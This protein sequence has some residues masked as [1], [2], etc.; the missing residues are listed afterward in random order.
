MTHHGDA[1]SINVV[2]A[3]VDENGDA[4]RNLLDM[5]GLN[6]DIAFRDLDED[7]VPFLDGPW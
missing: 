4:Y 1:L 7:V 5:D 3:D 6:R 2:G